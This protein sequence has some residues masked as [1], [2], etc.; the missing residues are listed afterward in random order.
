MMGPN[1]PQV[2]VPDGVPRERG[3]G[4]EN[5]NVL[6]VC[7]SSYMGTALCAICLL[8][9]SPEAEA[10]VET[11]FHRFCHTVLVAVMSC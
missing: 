5:A 4:R 8:P 7:W 10:F 2:A 3:A 11:C 9:I 6:R 1:G